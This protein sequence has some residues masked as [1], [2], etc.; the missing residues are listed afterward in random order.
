MKQPRPL[1]YRKSFL[2]IGWLYISAAHK[3]YYK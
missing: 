2:K 3:A 1:S